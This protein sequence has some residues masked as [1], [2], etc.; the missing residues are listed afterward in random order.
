MNTSIVKYLN[1]GLVVLSLSLLSACGGGGSDSS[2]ASTSNNNATT[3]Q[4]NVATT[5][6]EPAITDQTNEVVQA[7]PVTSTEDLVVTETFLF[8]SNYSVKVQADLPDNYNHLTICYTKQGS[9]QAD[10]SRCLLRAELDQGAFDGELLITNDTSRLVVSA[11]DYSDADNP[12]VRYWDREQ[13]GELIR[14]N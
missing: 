1:T 6:T 9:E 10:Y 7:G 5:V 14:I 3:T 2:E 12:S 4:T 8:S 13:D 11:W